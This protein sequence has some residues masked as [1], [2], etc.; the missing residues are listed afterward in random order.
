MKLLSSEAFFSAQNAANIIHQ[1]DSARTRWGRLQRF[2]K[3]PSWINDFQNS[4]IRS[5][6]CKFYTEKY[7]LKYLAYKN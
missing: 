4:N 5:V 6:C 1:P 7:F 2:T 3:P